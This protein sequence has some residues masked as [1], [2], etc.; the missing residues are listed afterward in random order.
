MK[1]FLCYLF[2]CL[3]T[4]CAIAQQVI[5][6][7]LSKAEFD[8]SNIGRRTHG[9]ITGMYGDVFIDTLQLSQSYINAHLDIK[10]LSTQNEK[11]DTHLKN[12]DF[13]DIENYPSMHFKS[14]QISI[15]NKRLFAIGTLTIKSI[16]K[17]IKVPLLF[18]NNILT[19]QFEINRKDYHVHNSSFLT[20]G[21][22]KKV[23]INF[24]IVL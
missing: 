14:S 13:F 9:T 11:R 1:R 18:K 12:E 19:G 4:Y 2:I 7:S 21:I 15:E 3:N 5:N 23:K 17:T 16:S 10:N 8:I 24:Y 20:K 6:S 22:G